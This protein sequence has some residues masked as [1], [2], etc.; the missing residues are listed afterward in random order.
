MKG[1]HEGSKVLRVLNTGT[2]VP[3]ESG[4]CHL[5]QLVG[6]CWF[7]NLKGLC[8]PSFGV[9]MEVL[10]PSPATSRNY[11]NIPS[12]HFQAQHLPNTLLRGR[13]SLGGSPPAEGPVLRTHV[14]SLPASLSRSSL[15]EAEDAP[16]ANSFGPAFLGRAR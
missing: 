3:M 10:F 4:G 5:A 12:L 15:P 7:S 2:S 14:A 16:S 9:F 8:T 13:L 1:T 11:Q 6:A